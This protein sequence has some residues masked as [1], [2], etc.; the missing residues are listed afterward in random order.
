MAGTPRTLPSR[1][2]LEL[3]RSDLK[4][5]AAGEGKPVTWKLTLRMIFLMPGFQFVLSRRIQDF[6]YGIPVVGRGLGRVWWW[7]T[8]RSFGCEIAIGAKVGASFY[9][10]HPTGIVLGVCTIGDG[11][12]ILQNVTIG[13]KSK[14]VAGTP[15]ICDGAYLAAGAVILGDIR[16]GVGAAVGANSVLMCDVPDG[17]F[18]VGAPARVKVRDNVRAAPATVR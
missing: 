16:V 4:V 1:S 10:P 15:V 2:T 9:T 11:V 17:C 12:T 18:A 13:K 5:F 3:I 14:L 6:L 7:W 8:C